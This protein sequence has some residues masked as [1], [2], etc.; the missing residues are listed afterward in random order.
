M[1]TKKYNCGYCG[2]TFEKEVNYSED[3]GGST[4]VKCSCGNYLPTWK[5]E[6]TGNVVGRKHIHI[7]Q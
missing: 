7:R 6:L 2:E 1:V 4:I 3:A 5:K